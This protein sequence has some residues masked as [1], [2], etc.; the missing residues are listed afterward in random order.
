M[1]FRRTFS[2]GLIVALFGVLPFVMGQLQDVAAHGDND[3]C[4]PSVPGIQ[5]NAG[6][7]FERGSGFS[8]AASTMG[9][10]GTPNG[11]ANYRADGHHLVR[12]DF[13]RLFYRPEDGGGGG[14]PGAEAESDSTIRM[15]V[16]GT[17]HLK[18]GTR[19]TV[20]IALDKDTSGD[21]GDRAR[22]RWRAGDGDHDNGCPGGCP[23]AFEQLSEYEFD[24]VCPGG[25]H[26]VGN[27]CP[28]DGHDDNGCPG[29][30]HDDNG[31]PGG[32]WDYSSGWFDINRLDIRQR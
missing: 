19:V 14:C 32:G 24:N 21:G 4:P 15:A 8:L 18:D 26:E 12:V 7:N 11:S 31:C 10:A 1:S 2:I 29:G 22:V 28:G 9:R 25:D 5:I 13:E 17:G 16:R 3:E 23:E 27:G 30:G 20:H 6:H